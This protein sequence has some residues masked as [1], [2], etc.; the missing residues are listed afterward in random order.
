[1]RVPIGFQ[2]AGLH[3]G[4]KSTRKDLA[5]VYSET[6]C[7][8]AGCF[9]ENLA[10]A[11]PV[12]DARERLPSEG[13]F[14]V[15]INSG[16]ANALTGPKG[17]DDVRASREALAK[18][19]GCSADAVL[20]CSTG[21]IGHPL[22]IAKM[23][24]ALPKLCLGRTVDPVPAAEAIMTTDTR[25]K[26]G[27]RTFEV[28]GKTVMLS[29]ICKGSGMVQPSLATVLAVLTTDCAISPEWLASSLRE[30]MGSS[31]N[32]LSVDGDMS[33]NDS[34]LV[35]ANGRA[36]NAAI[37]GPGEDY[38]VFS[39]A[40]TDLCGQLAREVAADGEGA[41]K[42]LEVDVKGAPT[43]AIAR[44]L[45]RAVA[46]SNL[47]KAAVF[48]ADP[49]WGRI[50]AAVGGRAGTQR[51]PV[52]PARS[53]VTVQGV[54][55]YADGPLWHD[56]TALKAKMREPLVRVLVELSQG[57]AEAHAWG[58]DLSYDYVKLNADYTSLLVQAP[59]GGVSRDN[60]LSNYSPAFKTSLLVGALSYISKF[61]GQR[62]VIKYGG[63]AMVKESLKASFCRDV[64]LLRSVGLQPIVVHGGGPEMVHAIE[65]LTGRADYVDGQLDPPDPLMMEMVLS[66]GINSELVTLLNREAEAAVG[67]SGKDANL[68]RAKPIPGEEGQGE[69]TRVNKDFLEM[70]LKQGYLPVISPVGI[71]EDGRTLN[72]NADRV[73][74]EVALAVGASKLIFLTDVAGMLRN[75]ELLSELN[76]AEL[77]SAV[78]DGTV[79]GGMRVKAEA[80]VRALTG[81]VD[82]VHIVDG[83]IPNSVIA[84]LFTD[85]GVGTLVAP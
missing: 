26:V 10:A 21:V 65:K 31:F 23:L 28:A 53:R 67:L 59:D 27:F 22:P 1:M 18:E 3:A 63:A 17:L 34:I 39:A 40:L 82:R 37:T 16:S 45:A 12:R 64:E 49:N 32:S 76:V 74:A 57:P 54:E 80:S 81:G 47:V 79:T 2:F 78:A 30:A 58:C 11:A 7:T 33:T 70:L 6:P 4:L 35:L 68:L 15:L 71:S 69:I 44:D 75:G 85:R 13:I 46:G 5:L 50:L 51:Y 61:R 77:Q 62:C 56:P 25:L 83:R 38:D 20:C 8:A 29:G 24:H 42:L 66:G 55:V 60:R 41:T 14:A 19:L 73:A 72:I 43:V 52:D 48:G 36:G 9:T 84:E